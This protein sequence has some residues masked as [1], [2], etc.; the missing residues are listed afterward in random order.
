[1][2]TSSKLKR[3]F[4]QT[5]AKGDNKFMELASSYYQSWGLNQIEDHI[6]NHKISAEDIIC[7]ITTITC[8]CHFK[9]LG[10]SQN[11]NQFVIISVPIYDWRTKFEI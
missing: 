9:F 3:K 7:F 1:M 5:K 8:S 2:I 4:L 10:L 6:S 11:P